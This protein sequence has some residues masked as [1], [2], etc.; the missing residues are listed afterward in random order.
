MPGCWP[1]PATNRCGTTARASS[2]RWEQVANVCQTTIARDAARAETG[3]ARR[4]Y[5]LRDGR[6][7]DLASTSPPPPTE[8]QYAAALERIRS[9][10]RTAESDAIHAADAPR[11]VGHY[12][13]ARRRQPPIGSG[14]RLPRSCPGSARAIRRR[15]RPL[16]NEYFADGRVSRYDIAPRR[17]ARCSPTRAVL[18]A[19]RA[20]WEDLVDVTV[21]LTDMERD[22]AGTTRPWPNSFPTRPTRPAA[23]PL[24]SLHKRR[25]S[26]SNW[27]C[28]SCCP[29]RRRNPINLQAGS[30]GT[31]C[32]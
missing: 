30:T 25:R 10:Q 14:S 17:R 8:L 7:H 6:V 28:V 1:A 13:H 12:P 20:R 4:A 26:R 27:K 3:R 24:A 23:P 2:T 32:C 31:A 16:G 15:T 11:A 22:F 5:T 19:R 21:F 29:R 18:E 9:D